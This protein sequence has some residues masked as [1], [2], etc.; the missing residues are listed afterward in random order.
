MQNYIFFSLFKHEKDYI[1]IN[2]IQ[3]CYEKNLLSNLRNFIS[4]VR[5]RQYQYFEKIFRP[6]V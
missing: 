3:Y 1:C 4:F 6:D 2:I 5:K